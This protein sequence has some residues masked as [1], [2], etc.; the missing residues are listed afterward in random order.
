MEKHVNKSPCS[1]VK[2]TFFDGEMPQARR[3][4]DA[5]ALRSPTRTQ[6]AGHVGRRALPGRRP[7]A[8]ESSE[9]AWM[10][11][12][13]VDIIIDHYILHI[14]YVCIYI[15]INKYRGFQQWGVP[16]AIIHLIFGFSIM[17]RPFLG[18]PTPG[19]PHIIY[20]YNIYIYIIYIYNIYI[21]IYLFTYINTQMYIVVDKKNTCIYI[22][23]YMHICIVDTMHVYI[24][25]LWIHVCIYVY[26]H[27]YICVYIYVYIPMDPDTSSAGTGYHLWYHHPKSLPG[28]IW[29]RYSWIQYT[30]AMRKY[31]D[32]HGY[33]YIWYVYVCRCI[34]RLTYDDICICIYIYTHVYT[35]TLH[36]YIYIYWYA[37][38]DHF[39]LGLIVTFLHTAWWRSPMF[40]FNIWPTST[41]DGSDDIVFEVI[42]YSHSRSVSDS[43]YICSNT[44]SSAR[45][46][47]TSRLYPYKVRPQTIDQLVCSLHS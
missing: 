1:A 13:D 34:C 11:L 27:I 20:I 15:Y 37:H 36:V 12:K 26:T 38:T 21:Y 4:A 28:R 39:W 45:V 40:T 14:C 16:L 7:G 18:I 24:Y 19:T 3:S 47:Q 22:Y 5:A 33:I 41:Q 46:S 25:I 23:I 17:N 32:P 9:G 44:I 2:P 43:M 42:D 30:M 31:L 8:S 6:A 35:H 29:R 10:R